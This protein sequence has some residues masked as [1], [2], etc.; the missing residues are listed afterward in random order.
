LAP[1]LTSNAAAWILIAA[2]V[3]LV[4]LLVTIGIHLSQ[5]LHQLV[6]SATRSSV[7]SGIGTLSW[8]TFLPCSL[9]FGA[10]SD[11]G[12]I[13]P[14]GWIITVVVGIAGTM[15]V[16]FSRQ[17]TRCPDRPFPSPERHHAASST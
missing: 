8:L 16:R 2:Q 1:A 7:S 10:L 14:A 15:L 12:G 11:H 5:L 13:R 9:P 3:V 6:P 4:V 17:S